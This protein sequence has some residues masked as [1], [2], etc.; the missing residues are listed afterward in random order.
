MSNLYFD[1]AAT[2]FP[3]PEV[4]ATEMLKAAQSYAVNAGRGSYASARLAKEKIDLCR[5]QLIDLAEL[6]GSHNLIFSPSATIAMNQIVFGL[7]INKFTNIY[8]SPFDHNAAIRPIT[9]VCRRNDIQFEL[10]PFDKNLKFDYEKCEKNFK[11]KKPDF[12]FCSHVSNVTGLVLPLKE[13]SELAKKYGAKLIID[14]AQGLGS[15]NYN[16]QDCSPDFLVF[17]GHKSLYGP[18]GIGGFMMKKGLKL[19]QYIFGGT[20][21]DSLNLS[22]PSTGNEQYEAGSENILGIAGLFSALDWINNE[23]I[24]KIEEKER[25]LSNML[26]DRLRQIEGV[27]LYLPI[28]LLSH[29]GIVSFNID[30]YKCDEVGMILDLDY[31]I[32]VRTGYHCA[33]LVHDLIGSKEFNGTVRASV[34]YFNNEDDIEYFVS[35]IAKLAEE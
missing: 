10:L 28:D 25:A 1:N 20:G 24:E 7:E 5:M 29:K 4:V 2:S 6:A 34:G 8:I 27:R 14:S 33:A 35:A 30:G 23:G 16:Y 17:A 21:T 26:I 18:F 19:G 11:S 31:G 3:K 13:I 32:S 9:E 15:I 22:M 12:V